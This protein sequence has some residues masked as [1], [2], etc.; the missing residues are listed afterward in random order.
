MQAQDSTLSAPGL[1]KPGVISSYSNGWKQLWK[2]FLTLFLI[3][4]IYIALSVGSWILGLIPVLGVVLPILYS[5][6]FLSPLGYG[7]SF[8]YLKASRNDKV[9]VQDIF[10]VFS[11]YWNAVGAYLLIMIIIIAGFILLIVP[12][13]FLACKLAFVPYLVVDKK[14]GAT[15]AISASWKMT[16]GHGWK[17]FLIGLLGILIGIAGLI[18]LVVGV[19]ISVMWIQAALASLYHAVNTEKAPGQASAPSPVMPA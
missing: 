14:M 19:I 2:H 11:N 7:Q 3:W 9:E 6:F 1:F 8:A 12:G 16:K 5:I 13:I 17:V 18:C 15:E 10:T 4:I